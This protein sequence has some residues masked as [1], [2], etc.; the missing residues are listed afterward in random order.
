MTTGSRPAMRWLALALVLRARRRAAAQPVELAQLAQEVID[1]LRAAIG[2]RIIVTTDFS[3]RRILGVRGELE[4]LLANLLL[5]ALDAMP[6]GGLLHVAVHSHVGSAVLEVAHDGE[7]PP[8]WL[9]L[10]LARRIVE[11]HHGDLRVVPHNGHGLV[12]RVVLPA[13]L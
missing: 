9:G 12:T 6:G 2:P 3:P 4:Q 13:G 8:D 5:N 1:M 11:H 10:S 7:P